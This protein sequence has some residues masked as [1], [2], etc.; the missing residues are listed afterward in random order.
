MESEQST[1]IPSQPTMNKPWFKWVLVMVLVALL[2][3]LATYAVTISMV[4][5]QQTTTA[6]TEEGRICPDGTHVG[7]TPPSCDFAACPTT[8]ANKPANLNPN[9]GNLYTD[10][11]VR[12]N[13][14]LK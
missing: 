6:C 2:S 4:K 11:K 8:T 12:M 10:I 13:E 1:P 7:R 5:Q 9:T 14:V 3:S